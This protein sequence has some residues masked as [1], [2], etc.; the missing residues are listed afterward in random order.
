MKQ[1]DAC[2]AAEEIAKCFHPVKYRPFVVEQISIWYF[3]AQD[4]LGDGQEHR[5]VDTGIMRIQ[6]ACEAG[7]EEH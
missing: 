4:P 6:G 2:S 5:R 1:K 7:A 3:S